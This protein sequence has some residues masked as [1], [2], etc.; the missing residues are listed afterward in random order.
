MVG[1][2]QLGAV[3]L[4]QHGELDTSPPVLGVA[5]PAHVLL[6]RPGLGFGLGLGLGP[7]LG[8][9]LGLGARG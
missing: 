8:L 3:V 9:G 5:D 1:C 4:R 2:Y 7:G 6:R